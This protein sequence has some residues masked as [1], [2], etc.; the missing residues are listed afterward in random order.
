MRYNCNHD[1][2]NAES[3]VRD[4]DMIWLDDFVNRLGYTNMHKYNSRIMAYICSLIE[5]NS[6]LVLPRAK[7]GTTDT[8][9]KLLEVIS[10]VCMHMFAVD[11]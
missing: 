11:I 8:E 10:N 9:N 1:L 4:F 3:R 2:A 7:V 5:L 6:S